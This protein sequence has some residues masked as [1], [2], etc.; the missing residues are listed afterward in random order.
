MR[1]DKIQTFIPMCKNF[2]TIFQLV[3]SGKKVYEMNSNCLIMQVFSEEINGRISHNYRL[4]NDEIIQ[5]IERFEVR[6]EWC[7]AR[8]SGTN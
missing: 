7:K 5:S 8:F 3:D 4:S 2:E 1:K 6:G